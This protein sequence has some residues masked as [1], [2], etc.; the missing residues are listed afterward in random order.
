MVIRQSLFAAFSNPWRSRTD[1]GLLV[2]LL[3]ASLICVCIPFELDQLIFALLGAISYVALQ[4]GSRAGKTRC[5]REAEREYKQN[6]SNKQMCASVSSNRHRHVR[7]ASRSDVAPRARVTRPDVF[8]ISAL[9][10]LPPKFDSCGFDAEVHE[11]VKQLTP[12][13]DEII[14]VERLAQYVQEIIQEVL[15]QAGVTAFVHG[16]LKRGTAFSVAVPELDLVTSVPL[17]QLMHCCRGRLGLQVYGVQKCKKSAIRACTDR[18]L[19]KGGMRFRRSAFKGEEPRMTLL[20]MP[21]LGFF[22]EGVPVDFSINALMPFY[23]SALLT[24]S[25]KIEPRAKAIM[26]FVKRWAKDRGICHV[27][28][29]HLSP[30]MWSLLVMYFLQVRDDGPLLP[31]LANFAI[32]S[33]LLPQSPTTP[34]SD[35]TAA[36]VSG[37]ADGNLSIGELFNEFVT[38]YC[39]HFDFRNEVVCVR[40]GRRAHPEPHLPI[41]VVLDAN[42]NQCQLVPAIEDPF[43]QKSN[44][45]TLMNAM[46]L[47]R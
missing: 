46:S 13:A 5:Q 25:G 27:A 43:N 21:E 15:P 37:D 32:S 39:K 28:K 33:G 29:G 38:F 20:I 19:A 3:C 35:C 30:Y 18:L 22:T 8:K 10:V 44:L 4:K 34:P 47:E 42:G 24:E 2:G 26:L 23:T 7:S 12:N 40:L 11:L 1:T 9:P 6:N 45:S 17:A 14:G 36:D 31:P 41:H 16:S